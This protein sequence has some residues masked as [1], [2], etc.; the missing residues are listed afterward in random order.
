[1]KTL[2][3]D[4][5]RDFVCRDAKQLKDCCW[6]QEFSE[7]ASELCEVFERRIMDLLL[8]LESLNIPLESGL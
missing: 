1:M 7:G 5:R 6:E 8:E 2:A 3:S 4:L